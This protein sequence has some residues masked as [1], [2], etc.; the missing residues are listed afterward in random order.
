[1]FFLGDYRGSGCLGEIFGFFNYQETVFMGPK[2][3]KKYI[4]YYSSSEE[5]GG[6]E[7]FKNV[8]KF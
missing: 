4:F 6:Q 1:M 5:G 3:A 7:G 2:R 8:K